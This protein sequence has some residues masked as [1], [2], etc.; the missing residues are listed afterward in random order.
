[1]M[2]LAP[3]G[4]KVLNFPTS[5]AIQLHLPLKRIHPLENKNCPRLS[6]HEVVVDTTLYWKAPDFMQGSELC[7]LLSS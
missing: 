3:V 4:H 5:C 2:P 7:V 1:M 6:H